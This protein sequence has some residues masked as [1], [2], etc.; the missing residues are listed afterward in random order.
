MST[1]DR[2]LEIN[3]RPTAPTV[4]VVASTENTHYMMWQAM[5]FHY[6]CVKHLG[7]VPTIVVHHDGEPLLPG[8]ERIAQRGGRIQAAPNYRAHKG[9]D[10]PPRNSAGSLLQLQT[11]ADFVFLC[12][13]DMIFLHR[14]PF[15]KYLLREDQISF[16]A[17]EYLIP[18]KAEFEGQLESICD[19]AGVPLQTLFDRPISGGVPHMIPRSKQRA[20]SQ[21]WFDCMELFPTFDLGPDFERPRELRAV[22]HQFWTTTMWALVLTAHRLKLEAV[23]THHCVLNYWG[24]AALP[25]PGADGPSM[26]HYC[27]S[28][29]G[30]DKRAHHDALAAERTVWNLPPDDGTISG[31]IRGQLRAAREYFEIQ[32]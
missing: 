19:R 15:E 26:I 3:A 9:V 23:I 28:N 6:S 21:D 1:V 16:D 10:Y 13:P 18:K 2:P 11:D 7:Q 4:E 5:L 27:Y 25:V 20:V 24:S 17:V 29:E 22:P 8:F 32:I 14:I 30:F 31:A 12:D